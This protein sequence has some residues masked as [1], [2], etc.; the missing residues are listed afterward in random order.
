MYTLAWQLWQFLVIFH[1]DCDVACNTHTQGEGERER[2]RERQRV[3]ASAT[4]VKL[5]DN[6]A[7]LKCVKCKKKKQRQLHL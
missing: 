7:Q 4:A 5:L 3:V 2:E 6:H 1:C